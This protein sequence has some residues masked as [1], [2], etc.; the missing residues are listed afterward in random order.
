[1]TKHL[2]QTVARMVVPPFAYPILGVAAALGLR[3][4]GF[5]PESRFQLLAG[6]IAVTLGVTGMAWAILAQVRRGT[7]PNP[8]SAANSLVVNGPYRFSRNPIYL[9]DLLLVAGAV[10]VMT[11]PWALALLVPVFLGLRR[12][13]V[14]HEEPY[15]E[16]RFG[17]DYREYRRYTPRWL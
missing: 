8:Y 16:S 7:S 12:V 9:A 13:V 4:L 14:R 3:L 6:T 11:K 1:M 2:Q 10:L 17:D 5:G 15:L